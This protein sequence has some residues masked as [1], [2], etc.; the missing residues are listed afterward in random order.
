MAQATTETETARQ[1][2][3]EPLELL[4][5]SFLVFMD[6]ITLMPRM[7]WN[8]LFHGNPHGKGGITTDAKDANR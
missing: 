7:L 1:K 6:V 8:T 5:R 2:Y 4:G 3:I